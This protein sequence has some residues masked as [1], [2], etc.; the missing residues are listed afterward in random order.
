MFHDIIRRDARE[1]SVRDVYAAMQEVPRQ[2]RAQ[3]E[4][5]VSEESRAGHG[6][7]ADPQRLPPLPDGIEYRFMGRELI[8]RDTNANLIVDFI[9]EAGPH[10]S[11]VNHASCLSD[12]LSLS[13]PPRCCRAS[14][15]AI[16]GRRAAS[17]SSR[18]HGPHRRPG[19]ATVAPPPA[20][21]GAD[22][23]QRQGL[24]QVRRDR[25]QRHR[26]YA[27][28]RVGRQMAAWHAKC[29]FDFVDHARRQHLRQR[30]SRR[31]S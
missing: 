12:S 29:P 17:P 25:G 10:D 3:G 2:S 9:H 5:R 22:A 19:Q 1:R 23:A 30:R 14:A 27:A 15:A 24:G 16:R 13:R 4:R 26:R 11:A 8:L 21:A 20:A 18:Q 7:A 6:A 31:T 28:V